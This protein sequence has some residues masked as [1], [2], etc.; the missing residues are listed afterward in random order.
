MSDVSVEMAATAVNYISNVIQVI[1]LGSVIANLL[2]ADPSNPIVRMLYETTE[3][4][5]RPIRKLTGKIPG[6]LDWAPLV[7]MLIVMT[8]RAGILAAIGK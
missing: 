2:G 1:V 6:P 8:A 4:V 5:Y 7:V 3:P